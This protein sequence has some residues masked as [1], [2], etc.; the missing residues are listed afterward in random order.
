MD[1]YTLLPDIQQLHEMNAIKNEILIH[2]HLTLYKKHQKHNI[3][4]HTDNLKFCII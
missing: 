3:T 1:M 4:N 2:M